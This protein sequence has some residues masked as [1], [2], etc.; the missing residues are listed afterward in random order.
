MNTQSPEDKK[1]DER[2][3]RQAYKANIKA[4]ELDS[5]KE[6]KSKILKLL[7]IAGILVLIITIIIINPFRKEKP[8]YLTYKP[9]KEY[10][11][12]P[13]P[14]PE[15]GVKKDMNIPSD[16]NVTAKSILVYDLDNN[17]VLYQKDARNK[18]PMASLTKIM[19]SMLSLELYSINTN[20]FVLN[21]DLPN[22]YVSSLVLKKDESITYDNAIEALLVGSAN[23]VAYLFSLKNEIFVKQMNEKAKILGLVDTNFVDSVGLDSSDEYST[24]YDITRLSRIFLKYPSLTSIVKR[25]VVSITKVLSDST[26]KTQLIYNTNTLLQENSKVFGLKTGYTEDAGQCLVT[27]YVTNEGKYL[28]TILGSEDRFADTKIILKYLK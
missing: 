26:P 12:S 8:E 5:K 25:K 15:L 20:Q 18:L 13:I 28:I 11:Y 6:E 7:G 4:R 10:Q 22:E 27:Y 2:L 19:T 1:Y 14:L 16:I 9:I 17:I 24:A 21:E 3:F 23:D